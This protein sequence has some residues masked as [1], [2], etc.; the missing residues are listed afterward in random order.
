MKIINNHIHW[1]QKG[2]LNQDGCFI[3]TSRLYE[4]YKH[5]SKNHSQ[6]ALL[7]VDLKG[8]FDRI[9]HS[10]LPSSIYK[11]L[12]PDFT[13]L[14]KDLISNCFTQLNPSHFQN[15][16]NNC[17]IPISNGIRQGCPLSPLIF[18]Y[19]INDLLTNLD[20]LPGNLSFNFPNKT[21]NIRS[22][23]YADDIII[24]KDSIDSLN[25]CFNLV[26]NWCN[27]SGSILNEKKC[28]VY[29][30]GK[31]LPVDTF[32]FSTLSIPVLNEKEGYK[33]LGTR[34]KIDN[35]IFISNIQSLSNEISNL[36]KKILTHSNLHPAIKIK[37]LKMLIFPKLNHIIRLQHSPNQTL[38][39]LM[40]TFDL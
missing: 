4:I 26:N 35:D 38:N 39:I 23:A 3:N 10:H 1:G 18:N 6:A 13:S 12:D 11:F 2:F 14:Y 20:L 7:F 24:M 21:F 27:T 19:A 31:K 32:K 30:F 8:A 28:A 34:F 36:S 33:Y 15:S 29:K 22:L 16:S 37:M 5:C 25:K 9:K 17:N 40:I